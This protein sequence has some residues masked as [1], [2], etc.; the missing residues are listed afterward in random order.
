M[1]VQLAGVLGLDNQEQLASCGKAILEDLGHALQ[2]EFCTRGRLERA[3]RR[4]AQARD[5]NG[6]WDCSAELFQSYWWAGIVVVVQEFVLLWELCPHVSR[7]LILLS[8]AK[9]LKILGRSAVTP[10]DIKGIFLHLILEG[11]QRRRA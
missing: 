4:E 8:S 7:E 5:V 2:D 3:V 9:T 6:R 10:V 11:A 1:F